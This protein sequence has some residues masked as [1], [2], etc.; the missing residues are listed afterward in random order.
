MRKEMPG[1]AGLSRVRVFCAAGLPTVFGEK[2]H[3]SIDPKTA[4]SVGGHAL[5]HLRGAKRFG[6]LSR[7]R[8]FV[9]AETSGTSGPAGRINQ[10]FA[11]QKIYITKKMRE[12]L[13]RNVASQKNVPGSNKI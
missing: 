6:L 7:H 9:V 1:G 10:V 11:L 13:G 12:G 4:E 3:E 5:P 8:H 2:L